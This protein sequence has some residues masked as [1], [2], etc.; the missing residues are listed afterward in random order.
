MPGIVKFWAGF[1]NLARNSKVW[2]RFVISKVLAR[3]ANLAQISKVWARF[4]NVAQTLNFT[5]PGYIGEYIPNST[6]P[7]NETFND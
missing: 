7:G 5:I 1:T 4:V 3:F 2:A 6:I